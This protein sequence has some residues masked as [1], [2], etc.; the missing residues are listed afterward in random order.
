ML[1]GGVALVGLGT[2]LAMAPDLP[3]RWLAGEALVAPRP[4]VGWKDKAMAGLATMALVR[5]Q[6][7]LLA[8]GRETP[9]EG[10][11]L[12]TLLL[13]QWRAR[14]LTHRYRAWRSAHPA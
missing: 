7:R 6:L 10:S 13:D 14:R 2:A 12:W 11:P 9:G 4:Q 5:R 1:A 8:S 3:R